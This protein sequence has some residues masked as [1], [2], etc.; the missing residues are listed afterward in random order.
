[1]E[2]NIFDYS[3]YTEI[4]KPKP[5]F[6]SPVFVL[7]V[8]AFAFAVIGYALLLIYWAQTGHFVVLNTKLARFFEFLMSAVWAVFIFFFAHK[9]KCRFLIPCVFA[10]NVI[11]N[12]MFLVSNIINTV[13]GYG[14]GY[15]LNLS[16]IIN[17]FIQ[18]IIIAVCVMAITDFI[19][20]YSSVAFTV[21]AVICICLERAYYIFGDIAN[22]I[23]NFEYFKPNISV[24]SFYLRTLATVI[25]YISLLLFVK[26]EQ[27]LKLL[28]KNKI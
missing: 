22:I 10:V 6:S 8:I 24:I 15:S 23:L 17:M 2:N 3:D 26:R 27:K 11:T 7:A 13:I 1:M 28:R 16:Q 21:I 18:I 4:K 14:Y 19:R 20:G 5:Q 12:I 9:Q 25:T